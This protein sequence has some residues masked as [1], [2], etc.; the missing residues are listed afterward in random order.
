METFKGVKAKFLNSVHLPLAGSRLSPL[1]GLYAFVYTEL[2]T[3][4]RFYIRKVDIFMALL[5]RTDN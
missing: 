3:P 5:V 1:P 2:R 4:A